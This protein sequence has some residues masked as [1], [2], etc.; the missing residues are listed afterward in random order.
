MKSEK[1]V[2]NTATEKRACS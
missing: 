2:C 1:E